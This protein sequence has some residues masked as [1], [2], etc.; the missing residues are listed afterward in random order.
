MRVLQVLCEVLL[1]VLGLCSISCAPFSLL[2]TTSSAFFKAE[3]CPYSLLPFILDASC[4][5]PIV[6]CT[7]LMASLDTLIRQPGTCGPDLA[8]GNAL[9]T[10]AQMGFM[11]YPLMREAGCQKNNK[12]DQ[13]RSPR[14]CAG[15]VGS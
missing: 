5:A 11:N 8:A 14:R 7:N 15:R 3:R 4:A 12:T 2:L 9:A 13:V 10:Q 1:I 6:A